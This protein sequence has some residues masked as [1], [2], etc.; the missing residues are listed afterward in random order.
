MFSKIFLLSLIPLIINIAQIKSNYKLAI[1]PYVSKGIDELSIQTAESILKLEIT[2][3]S[4][5]TV[6][7]AKEIF[8]VLQNNICEDIQC[9]IEIGEQLNADKVLLCK[10]K[11]LG[12]NL[13]IQYYLYDLELDSLILIEQTKAMGLE[14]LELVM[15]RIAKSIITE[16][17]FIQSVEVGT[18]VSAESEKFLKKSSIYNFGL[19]FGYLFPTYG[20]DNDYSKSFTLNV[21]FD[22]E[23]PKYAIGLMAGARNGFA[24]NI[25]GHSF[26][27]SSDISPYIGAA[28]G[29][30][31]VAH[32]QNFDY[33]QTVSISKK[34]SHGFE[35]TLSS[36]VRIFRTQKF[37]VILNLE[38][39]LT[40]ND[41]NDK[42]LVFTIGL[43]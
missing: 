3:H 20:Y 19:T 38:Y 41:Y 16:T 15:K 9:A 18:V 14:D 25:Y 36:G 13:I 8:N 22:Y 40:F 43:L 24:I 21:H 26:L 11:P 17:P 27:T 30:H 12:T 10:I 7:E 29:F 6:I 33:G 31:W 42:A 34:D 39:L 4:K 37:T 1:L 32:S 23:L 2:K 28:F 35:I 5:I